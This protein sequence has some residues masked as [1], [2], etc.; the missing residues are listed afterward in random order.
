[1]RE[2]TLDTDRAAQE[3][4]ATTAGDGR[5]GRTHLAM[6]LHALV[7]R[8]FVSVLVGPLGGVRMP[9]WVPHLRPGQ[10]RE[11][12]GSDL[13]RLC[14]RWLQVELMQAM[15]QQVH[16]HHRRCSS[17]CSCRRCSSRCMLQQHQLPQRLQ[18]IPQNPSSGPRVPP[19]TTRS[20]S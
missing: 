4:H 6:Q 15:Q 14:A 8:D 16:Q 7:R 3:A 5:K 19:L 20:A 18:I 9:F 1:M 2:Q 10:P 17:R 13:T 12:R 11:G